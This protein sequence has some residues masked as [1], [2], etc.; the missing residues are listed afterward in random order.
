METINCNI[1]Q[2]VLDGFQF[3]WYNSVDPEGDYICYH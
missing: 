1:L 3:S 2:I